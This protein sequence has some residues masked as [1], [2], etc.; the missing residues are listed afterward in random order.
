MLGKKA[1]SSTNEKG[2]GEDDLDEEMSCVSLPQK[3][4]E[5]VT[6]LEDESDFESEG[7]DVAFEELSDSEGSA[8]SVEAEFTAEEKAYL[9]ILARKIPFEPEI[10]SGF[11]KIAGA[12]KGFDPKDQITSIIDKEKT[13][14][15]LLDEKIKKFLASGED[16]VV[17]KPRK[18]AY[19]R[20][21]ERKARGPPKTAKD[22]FDMPAA[23]KTPEFKAVARIIH[24]REHLFKNRHYKTEERDAM[25]TFAQL[26]TVIAGPADPKLPARMRKRSFVEQ[27]LAEEEEL[28]MRK[29]RYHKEMEGRRLG[30]RPKTKRKRRKR[31]KKK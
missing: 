17:E 31:I 10:D 20:K 8:W 19:Q 9:S 1:A 22:W 16:I 11:I 12:S 28:K 27:V 3:T 25:P 6:F 15:N 29:E 5:D 2:G 14:M 30:L 13:G 7:G 24:L 18:T 23:A 26:G 4:E 21:K